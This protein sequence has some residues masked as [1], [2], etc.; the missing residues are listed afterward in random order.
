MNHSREF[1]EFLA[2]SLELETEAGERYSEL[3]EAMAAHNKPIG[4]G[5]RTATRSPGLISD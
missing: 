5:P 4:P 1:L 3:A 2:H